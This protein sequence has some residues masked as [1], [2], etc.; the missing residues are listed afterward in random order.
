VRRPRSWAT[1]RVCPV[2]TSWASIGYPRLS[3]RLIC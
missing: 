3:N 2:V 1:G